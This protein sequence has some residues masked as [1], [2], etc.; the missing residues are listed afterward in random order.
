MEEG[1][2]SWSL[3]FCEFPCK[4]KGDRNHVAFTALVGLM[5]LEQEV[6]ERWFQQDCRVDGGY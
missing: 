5:P 6:W 4:V 2:D 1:G 3:A